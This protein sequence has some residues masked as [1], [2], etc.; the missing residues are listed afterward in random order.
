ML[1]I[2]DS[3][4]FG[5]GIDPAL[6]NGCYGK[7]ADHA[8]P[9]FPPKSILNLGKCPQKP[10]S[11]QKI[12]L[13]FSK[14]P[15]DIIIFIH[16]ELAMPHFTMHNAKFYDRKRESGSRSTC[17]KILDASTHP[18]IGTKCFKGSKET[19]FS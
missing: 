2:I 17:I 15:F 9:A 1:K 7:A 13:T 8:F 5:V 6:V 4:F 14:A 18:K 11:Q 3:Q 19:Q 12:S 16:Q 10:K